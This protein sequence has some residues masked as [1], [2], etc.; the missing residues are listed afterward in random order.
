VK[1]VPLIFHITSRAQWEQAEVISSYHPDTLDLEGFIHCSTL[2]QVIPVAN[3]LYHGQRELIL[4]CIDSI[5]VI[6]EIQY[7]GVENGEQYPHIYGELNLDSV[8]K[9]FDFNLNE[10]GTYELPLGVFDLQ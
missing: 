4:V 7:E 8:I 10:N 3:A 9:V 5:K 2:Q 1:I 6:P